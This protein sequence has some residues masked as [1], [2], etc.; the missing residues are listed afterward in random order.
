M[1]AW[2]FRVNFTLEGQEPFS[3]FE[4]KLKTLRRNG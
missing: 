4:E 1:R 3:D 2:L